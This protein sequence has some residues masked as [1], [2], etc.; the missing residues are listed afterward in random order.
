MGNLGKLVIASFLLFFS[1]FSNASDVERLKVLGV[2]PQS[3][4]AV[5]KFDDNK[6]QVLNAGDA[7]RGTEATLIQVLPDKIIASQP[8]LDNSGAQDL[9]WIYR[10]KDT[11]SFSKVERFEKRPPPK[12]EVAQPMSKELSK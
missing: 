8:S 9:L 10:I 7:I 4:Q 2:N 6:M 1:A 11:T 5:I 12:N 3:N